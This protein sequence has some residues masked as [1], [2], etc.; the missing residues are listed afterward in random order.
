MMVHRDAA[1]KAARKPRRKAEPVT[2]TRL[3]PLAA[4]T[5]KA[6]AAKVPGSVIRITGP[7]SAIIWNGDYKHPKVR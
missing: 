6:L 2:V 1:V 3:S 7:N 4:M 5:V